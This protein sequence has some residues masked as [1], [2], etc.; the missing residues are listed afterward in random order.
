M[1]LLND[2]SNIFFK[3]ITEETLFIEYKHL[4][5]KYINN[6]QN[7]EE[8]HFKVYSEG[9]N[10]HDYYLT[11][12]NHNRFYTGLFKC[13]IKPVCITEDK[14]LNTLNII[15]LFNNND[16]DI[17]N[18]DISSILNP[19]QYPNT[20]LFFNS[21]YY[22][23]HCKYLKKLKEE[24]KKIG[25]P[26]KKTMKCLANISDTY[27][28][29]K[30]IKLSEI[31]NYLNIK[32]LKSKNKNKPIILVL[33]SCTKLEI[34]NRL[35]YYQNYFYTRERFPHFYP[36][37]NSYIHDQENENFYRQHNDGLY[38]DYG[39]ENFINNEGMS[40]TKDNPENIS[41]TQSNVNNLN[42]I[43]NINRL[44]FINHYTPNSNSNNDGNYSRSN[45]NTRMKT[46]TKLLHEYNE[47]KETRPDRLRE[48]HLFKK[49]LK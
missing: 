13:P 37:N 1:G 11:T 15:D 2:F 23:L 49:K 36:E 17:N 7:I 21:T 25:L 31:V 47:K 34:S 12:E 9:D 30:K 29:K 8:K 3:E 40:S 43:N 19:F 18:H 42:E 33:K 28:I 45:I 16:I 39:R 48:L 5:N 44:D 46:F 6:Y 22:T 14:I 27:K 41:Y 38:I 20:K 10:M 26:F 35:E 32:R 24:Q 4:L